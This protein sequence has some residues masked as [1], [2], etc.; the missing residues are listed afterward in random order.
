MKPQRHY[1]LL[2]T[3]TQRLFLLSEANGASN[4]QDLLPVYGWNWPEQTWLM[5]RLAEVRGLQTDEEMDH[6]PKNTDQ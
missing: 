4:R 1:R 2:P 6:E 3:D 5:R